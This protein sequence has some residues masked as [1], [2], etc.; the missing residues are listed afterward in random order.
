M[1]APNQIQKLRGDGQ[2]TRVQDNVGQV[3]NPMAQALS[4]TPIMGS[5]PVWTEIE[6]DAAFAASSSSPPCLYKDA[7]MRVQTK[8]S[9]STSAGVAANA[10][11]FTFG[12][13]L[14]PKETQRLPVRGNGATA[15]FVTIAPTGVVTCDVAI[16]AGGTIDFGF[17]FLAEQ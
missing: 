3:V 10:T 5:A 2:P 8:G 17:S 6:L 11:V 13:G 16:G 14:R 1:S 7:L 15:Q 4:R 9:A 12:A